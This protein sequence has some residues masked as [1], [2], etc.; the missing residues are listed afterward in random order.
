MIFRYKVTPNKA[1]TFSNPNTYDSYV[2]IQKYN[3]NAHIFHWKTIADTTLCHMACELDPYTS[4]IDSIIYP[5]SLNPVKLYRMLT[6]YENMSNF[7]KA[8]ILEVLGASWK[9]RNQTNEY[10]DK[11]FKFAVTDGWNAIEI[12]E[13]KN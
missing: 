6:R 3:E 11:I 12:K 9:K 7:V 4:D 13:D 1:S 2:K 10:E 8:Y 5:A